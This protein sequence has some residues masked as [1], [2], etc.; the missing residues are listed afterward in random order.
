MA[1]V[2][3]WITAVATALALGAA[4]WAGLTAR[5]LYDIERK[6]E[7]SRDLA[8]ERQ[9]AELVASWVSWTN[10]PDVTLTLPD[11]RASR[12]HLAMQNASPV[13]VYD[14]EV[15]YSEGEESLGSQRFHA[16]SP[17]GPTP[18]HREIKSAAVGEFLARP[19][20]ADARVDIRVAISFTDARG[21]R[22]ARTA[23][24]QLSREDLPGPDGRFR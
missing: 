24:G 23:A 13:P 12:A 1:E 7:A 2:P 19:R 6:R 20:S 8:D 3:D 11:G 10:Q 4:V 17:T 21:T 14:I 22:W 18:H 16:L 9:Q 15:E 5:K